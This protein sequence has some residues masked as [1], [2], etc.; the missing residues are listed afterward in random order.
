MVS[1]VAL[2]GPVTPLR[3]AGLICLSV[4][5]LKMSEVDTAPESG[6]DQCDDRR[7]SMEVIHCKSHKDRASGAGGER[8]AGTGEE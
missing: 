3:S 5:S 4:N 7:P 2:L 8:L 6:R 1:T